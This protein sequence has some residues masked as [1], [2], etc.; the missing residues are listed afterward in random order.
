MGTIA[1]A[2]FVRHSFVNERN[3]EEA[4][5]LRKKVVIAAIDPIAHLFNLSTLI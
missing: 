1:H 5:S 4:I 3:V 2:E